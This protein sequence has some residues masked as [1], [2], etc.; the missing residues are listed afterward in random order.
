MLFPVL[1]KLTMIACLH[2]TIV[3]NV[4]L[5]SLFHH[6]HYSLEC[7]LQPPPGR[8]FTHEIVEA[9]SKEST[10][11]PYYWPTVGASNSPQSK[12]TSIS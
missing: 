5:V 1:R 12:V 10:E 9:N 11:D 2:N 3:Y 8:R 4:K 6:V 7:R